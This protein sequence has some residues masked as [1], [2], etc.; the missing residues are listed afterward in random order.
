VNEDDLNKILIY[1][2]K[3]DAPPNLTLY[4][5][6]K[7]Q[8]SPG[9]LTGL[10]PGGLCPFHHDIGLGRPMTSP[11]SPNVLDVLEAIVCQ[12]ARVAGS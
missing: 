12:V 4:S 6:I 9:S 11:R 1:Y 2:K 3:N 5:S 7:I 10:D 8:H